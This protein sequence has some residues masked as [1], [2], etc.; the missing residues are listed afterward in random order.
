[1]RALWEIVAAAAPALDRLREGAASEVAP[2]VV[3]KVH[4][5]ECPVCHRPIALLLGGPR[6]TTP[7]PTPW[8]SWFAPLGTG[9]GALMVLGLSGCATTPVSAI[10]GSTDGHNAQIRVEFASARDLPP[11][12]KGGYAK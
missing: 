8:S 12:L 4:R 9:V 7:K 6:N 1:M 11:C 10:T 5:C 2:R 3:R